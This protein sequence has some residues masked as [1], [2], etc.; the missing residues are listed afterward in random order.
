ML[1]NTR[2]EIFFV[3]LVT[4]YVPWLTTGNVT[5]MESIEVNAFK[6]IFE[7]QTLHSD[8][9]GEASDT[10]NV[11]TKGSKPMDPAIFWK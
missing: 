9:I 3:V 7:F 11:R 8:D 10:L 5:F 4:K 6:I 1:E 2:L